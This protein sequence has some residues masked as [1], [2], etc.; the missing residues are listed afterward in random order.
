MKT[1]MTREQEIATLQSLKGDTYFGQIFD[2]E[3]IDRMCENIKN[4]FMLD[5]GI[6]LFEDAKRSKRADEKLELAK[7]I[8]SGHVAFIDKAKERETALVAL[9][10]KMLYSDVKN[11]R[12]E[13]ELHEIIGIREICKYKLSIG[14]YLN[15]KERA[16]ILSSLK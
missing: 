1:T 15:E 10:F 6:K 7:R 8:E 14:A 12:V 5:C 16:E 13:D 4:D 9:I 3:T 2:N 11:E